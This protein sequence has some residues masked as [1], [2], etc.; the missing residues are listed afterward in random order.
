MSILWGA[1]AIGS[2]INRTEKQTFYLLSRGLIR[3]AKRVGKTW[4]AD[5]DEL[6]RELR[7]G[8][9]RPTARQMIDRGAA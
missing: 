2:A 9:G 6:Q 3:S 7:T 1:A 8:D 5:A 4:C